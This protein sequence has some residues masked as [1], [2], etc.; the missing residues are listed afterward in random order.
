MEGQKE[1]A[2]RGW[3][4]PDKT[5]AKSRLTPR[6]TRKEGVS[7]W[8]GRSLKRKID[9]LKKGGSSAARFGEKVLN[10][11]EK[12]K[13]P[14]FSQREQVARSR[15]KKGKE[16]TVATLVEGRGSII[17]REHQSAKKKKRN[18]GL[19]KFFTKSEGKISSAKISPTSMGG[20]RL[21]RLE[22]AVLEKRGS[23]S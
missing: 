19:S 17:V 12:K 16:R 1:E 7:V 8:E 23:R 20:K 6:G 3:E 5:I 21:G 10:R 15:G 4:G 18:R 11:M 2:G 22:R 9:P 13:K 14:Y